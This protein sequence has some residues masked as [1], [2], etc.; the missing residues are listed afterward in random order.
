ML[1]IR[2]RVSFPQKGVE[3]TTAPFIAW[4]NY[5]RKITLCYN[6]NK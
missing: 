4:A 5:G 2:A 3:R 6:A 1:K